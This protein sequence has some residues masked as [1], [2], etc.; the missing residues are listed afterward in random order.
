VAQVRCAKHGVFDYQTAACPGCAND[1][2]SRY[3]QLVIEHENEKTGFGP[4]TQFVRHDVVHALIST[5]A[6]A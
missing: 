6:F 3:K 1:A 2:W 5:E 4:R